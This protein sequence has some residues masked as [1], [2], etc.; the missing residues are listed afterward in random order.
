MLSPF[1]GGGHEEQERS[2]HVVDGAQVASAFG[3]DSCL[4]LDVVVKDIHTL[5]GT[6]EISHTCTRTTR[7]LCQAGPGKLA[8]R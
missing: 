3:T 1:Q 5:R 4:G 6:G 8:H 7:G 2:V